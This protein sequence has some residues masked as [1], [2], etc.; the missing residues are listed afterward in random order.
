MNEFEFLLNNCLCSPY[1]SVGII[2]I[3]ALCNDQYFPGQNH[4][5][6]SPNVSENRLH[7]MDKNLSD[8]IDTYSFDGNYE[9]AY[10][11]MI[12]NDYKWQ[13]YMH[14]VIRRHK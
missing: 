6:S 9:G 1:A 8:S 3:F 13:I 14:K 11:I 10:L 12:V 4:V 2:L 7:K 5:I